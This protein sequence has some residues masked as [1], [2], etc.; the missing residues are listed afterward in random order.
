MAVN[1]VCQE[2]EGYLIVSLSVR[3]VGGYLVFLIHLRRSIKGHGVMNKNVVIR[4][5]KE[6]DNEMLETLGKMFRL[7]SNSKILIKAGHECIR[8]QEEVQRLCEIS[9]E[10]EKL[11]QDCKT[12]VSGLESLDQIKEKV[13][14]PSGSNSQLL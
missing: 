13:T 6:S 12:L 5:L 8:L 7:N 3:N 2:L 10:Y 1:A 4:N 14:K 11:K 9:C